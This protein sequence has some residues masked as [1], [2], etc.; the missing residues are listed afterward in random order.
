M[1]APL[2]S[3]MRDVNVTIPCEFSE[4]ISGRIINVHW[5]K[6]Q[7]GNTSD[8]YSFIPGQTQNFRPGSYMEEESEI[9]RGNAA[10]HIP[11]VQFSDDGEYTCT[12]IVTPDSQE[13]RSALQVSALPSAALTPGDDITVE[14]GSE[15]SVSCDVG[16]FYPKDI[17]IRWVRREKY[18]PKC[19]IL[20]RGTCTGDT[21]I[22]TDGTFNTSSQL[23]LYPTMEDDGCEYSCVITHRSLKMDPMKNFTL[24]VTE[25]ED[26]TGIVAAA[27]VSTV[28]AMAFLFVAGLFYHQALMKV[29]PSL[30]A[31]SGNDRLIDMNETTL[32]CQIMNFK[33]HDLEI[34]VYLRRRGE[35]MR[36]IHTWRSRDP[37]SSDG[38]VMADNAGGSSVAIHMERQSLMNVAVSDTQRP[39]QLSMTTNITSNR[40]R[41]LCWIPWQRLSTSS[42][43]CSVHITPSVSTDNGAEL[44]VHVLHPALAAEVCQQKTLQVIG[45]SPTLFK[46]VRP[47][48]VTHAE[49]TTLTCPIIGFKPKTLY[50][51]WLKKD[52][53]N[54][55]TQLVTWKSNDGTDI[56]DDIHNVTENEQDDKSYGFLSAITI[57]PSVREDD[58]VLYI[59]R[60]YHPATEHQAEQELVLK[61]TAVP[62]M[63]PIKKA[64]NKIYMGDIMNLSCKIHSFYPSPIEVTWLAEDG[65]SLP[66][67]ITDLLLDQ[68][69]LY[70]VTSSMNYSPTLKDLQKKFTCEV[71]HQSTGVPRTATWRLEDI[72][73]MPEVSEI[74]CSPVCDEKVTLSCDVRDLYPKEFTFQWYKGIIQIP[75]HIETF[76]EDSESGTFQGSV[77]L[78]VAADRGCHDE[79]FRM[80]MIHCGKPIERKFRM[81]LEAFA[82]LPVLGDIS[83][84]PSNPRYGQA[85]ILRC[86]VTNASPEDIEVKWLKS[87]KPVPNGGEKRIPESDGS[88]T[89]SL[90][91]T[92]TALDYTKPYSCC[93]THKNMKEPLKKSHYLSLPDKAP[94]VADITV[95]PERPVAG[96]EASFT[97]TISGFSPDIR[98]KWYKDFSAF[99][100]D[101]VTTSDPH[102]GQDFLCTCSSSLRFTPQ[103]NDHNASIGCEVTHSVTKKMYAQTYTLHLSGRTSE[104]PEKRQPIPSPD[105][106]RLKLPLKTRG[107]QCMTEDPRV[108]DKVTLTC[109]VDGSDAEFFWRKGMFPIDSD[110]QNENLE[111]GSGSFSTVTFTAQETDRDRTITCE[112]TYNFHTLEEHFTLKLH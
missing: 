33:P 98:V 21:I 23:T 38:E 85:V 71:K 29:A 5:S 26:N 70:H 27:V 88:I 65:R 13:G 14:L 18:S 61:V 37:A 95:R 8:V 103:Q 25:P 32:T 28:L 75:G 31:I 12:V 36:R 20:E 69:G 4:F 17:N 72:V 63:D 45:V 90:Q 112:A 93:V 99:P 110:I 94:V 107:I 102:I 22:N 44:S 46:I 11:Q 24:T 92:A 97:V 15:R 67:V 106:G 7:N 86:K 40:S 80:E 43:Q 62:V 48:H 87:E 68:T 83:S 57:R 78:T 19:V 100:S 96:E 59:C 84:D 47:A 30:S 34:S 56:R 82:G 52:Q 111:D 55:Q 2:I 60:T 49:P 109:H 35:E 77:A 53:R 101:V 79:E 16:N 91:I 1:K 73:S 10:L 108:G 51:T 50:I 39:L 42:C 9:K 104:E 74:C 89:C 64:Q 6:S 54:Q 76:Q 58:G 66:S 105:S 41:L 3:V 81:C